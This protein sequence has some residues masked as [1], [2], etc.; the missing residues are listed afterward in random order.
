M[1]QPLFA[2]PTTEHGI[3]VELLNALKNGDQRAYEKLFI[4]YYNKLIR[5]IDALIRS[6]PEAEDLTQEIFAQIW[7][8]R[9]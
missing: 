3:S 6:T 9:E 7:F 5:F 2:S 1:N 4:R 8:K